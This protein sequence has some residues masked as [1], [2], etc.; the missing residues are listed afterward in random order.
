MRHGYENK[1]KVQGRV[2]EK[3]HLLPLKKTATTTNNSDHRCNH[4]GHHT[5][6]PA[7]CGSITSP[8]RL[9]T[10]GRT[11]RARHTK[12]HSPHL[13]HSFHLAWAPSLAQGT[14]LDSYQMQHRLA[15]EESYS[16]HCRPSDSSE[17]RTVSSHSTRTWPIAPS[18]LNCR[19]SSCHR[20]QLRHQQGWE[21][22][23]HHV[24][25]SRNRLD[26]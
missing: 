15:R 10:A 3:L 9:R 14:V 18:G 4:E 1:E 21:H 8:T 24:G 26:Q 23:N 2:C 7:S 16:S 25:P 11:R 17:R 20:C 5:P 22:M 12:C 19:M 13:L 6:F